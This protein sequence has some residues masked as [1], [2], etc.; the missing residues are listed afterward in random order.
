VK[1]PASLPVGGAD[2]SCDARM[3]WWRFVNAKV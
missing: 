2:T 3:A 1:D